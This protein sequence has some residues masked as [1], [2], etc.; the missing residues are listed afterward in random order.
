MHASRAYLLPPLAALVLAA[1]WDTGRPIDAPAPER[2]QASELVAV[3]V[4]NHNWA[5]VMIYALI[6]GQSVRL[7][8]VE[9]GSITRLELPDRAY[10]ATDLELVARPL[11]SDE[12]WTT[13]PLVIAPG[14]VVELVIENRLALSHVAVR[15]S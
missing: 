12:S 1:C 10:T 15:G 2:P 14:S 13:G 6:R 4:T 5:R 11:A 9:T 3:Q 7:G 8:H